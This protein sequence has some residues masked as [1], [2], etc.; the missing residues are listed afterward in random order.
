VILRETKC[1]VIFDATHSLQLPGGQGSSSGGQKEFIPSLARAAVATGVAGIFI[2]THPD[3]EIA[4]SDGPNSLPLNQMSSL[5]HA[6]K[7]I[8][9]IIK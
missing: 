4:L 8:D 1:P 3:P 6:L 7:D 5:L 9:S 2:E